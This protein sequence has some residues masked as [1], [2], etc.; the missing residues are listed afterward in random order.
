MNFREN[1]SSPA[2]PHDPDDPE[3]IYL[4]NNSCKKT[5][6][7]V[8]QD[9]NMLEARYGV[10]EE[11]NEELPNQEETVEQQTQNEDIQLG[12]ED[13]HTDETWE[14]QLTP[15]L[16]NQLVGPWKTSVI[17][18]LMGRPLGY[19]ALQTRLAG[20]WRPTGTTHLIDLGYGFFI[21]RF[22]VLKDYQ[23]ALMDGPWFVGD[24]YLHVQAWEADFHPQT[25][26]ISTTAVWIRLEQ[27]PIEYYHP[28]FF[29]HVGKKLR[30]LL[31]VDVIT[32][33]AIRGRFARVCV[34]INM[35]NP[36]PK[37]VKIGSPFTLARHCI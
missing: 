16:K 18:K 30:K 14:I 11:D 27:L 10:G 34:Q 21:M 15:E 20:I 3:N 19:Q 33:A 8:I 37:R 22:D 7:E 35:A 13:E 31:K 25:A 12:T 17:L 29:K 9:A 36:L 23:H 28:E 24:H 1:S 32:S 6:A 5:Y 4:R 26:K 2:L